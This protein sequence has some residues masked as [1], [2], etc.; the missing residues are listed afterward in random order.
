MAVSPLI[1]SPASA[2]RNGPAS[3]TKLSANATAQ[4]G[5]KSDTAS[6]SSGLG[7]DWAE[8]MNEEEK[9]KYIKGAS[10]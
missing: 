5:T 3:K 1:I 10:A 8:Q 9:H 7:R 6:P 2:D 4:N